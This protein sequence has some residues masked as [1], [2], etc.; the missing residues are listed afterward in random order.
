[1]QEFDTVDGFRKQYSIDFLTQNFYSDEAWFTSSGYINSEN[2]RHWSTENPHTVQELP[3]HDLEIAVS[4][5]RI[6]GLMYFM[7][8]P[9]PNVM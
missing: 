5:W 8:Q 6:V 1:M 4:V 9:I 2:N 3:L 7:I